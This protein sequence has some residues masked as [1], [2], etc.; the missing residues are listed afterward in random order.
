MGLTTGVQFPAGEVIGLYIFFGTLS[1]PA[2]FG[3]HPA[4]CPMVIGALSLEVKRP[5]Y[6]AENSSPSSAEVKNA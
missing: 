4:S 1:R 3:A 6:E 5:G 2:G